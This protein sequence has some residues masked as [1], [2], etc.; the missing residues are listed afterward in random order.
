LNAQLDQLTRLIA[1]AVN[2]PLLGSY[3]T[4]AQAPQM[5]GDARVKVML[6]SLIEIERERDSYTAVG[7]VD[8][9]FVAL[10]ARANELGR[11]ITALAEA[12]RITMQREVSAL[13]PAAPSLPAAMASRPLPDTSAAIKK[14]SDARTAANGVAARLARERHE[15][16]LLDAREERA[17]ELSSVGASPTAILAAALVFGAVLGF[18]AAFFAEVRRPRVADVEEVERMVG[19]KVF[20][21]VRPLPVNPDRWRRADDRATPA[22]MDSGGDGHQL[23]YLNVAT[24]GSSTVMLTVTADVPAVAA[25]VAVNFAAIAADEARATLLVDTD[26][27]SASVNAALHMRPSEGFSGVARGADWA[28]VTRTVR[29]GRD[30]LID[31]VP[32]GT[33]QVAAEQVGAVLQRDVAQLARR[34]DALVFVS[35]L[36]QVTSGQP[37]NLPIPDVIVCARAG[38]TLLSDLEQIVATIR[39]TGGNP[40]GIVIWNAPDPVFA[41]VRPVEEV[42]REVGEKVPA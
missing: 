23:V 40:R 2:A 9:V 32:S 16:Q 10:T 19:V 25:V 35:A 18:G 30:R 34:Y 37:A 33:S 22:Y 20:G 41:K 36:E 39:E 14:L 12:R 28:D 5:Q 26:A 1:R 3:R 21:I 42:A 15:L 31:V 6:D 7:G 17:N 29:L 38:Q 27:T 4:L 8:P 11:N 13:A 24:S